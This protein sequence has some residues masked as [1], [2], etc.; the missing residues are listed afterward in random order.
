[1]PMNNLCWFAFLKLSFAHPQIYIY[2]VSI[3]CISFSPTVYDYCMID[4]HE[5]RFC[6]SLRLCKY[7]FEVY[8]LFAFVLFFFC[9]VMRS[10]E[11]VVLLLSVFLLSL[12][13]VKIRRYNR[14]ERRKRCWF[15]TKRNYHPNA[16][17]HRAQ[18]K[19][20]FICSTFLRFARFVGVC[21]C[22]YSMF[23]SVWPLLA[24]VHLI[25]N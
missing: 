15:R 24:E 25:T 17:V 13:R 2:I 3:S 19:F 4:K 9:S 6:F 23:R 12:S 21:M 20:W 1:M 7:C 10:V 14:K 18:Y 5:E 11:N 16:G 22:V 8:I